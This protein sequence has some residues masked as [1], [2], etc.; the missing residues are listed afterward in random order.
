MKIIPSHVDAG[1]KFRPQTIH[2]NL[3]GS[4][5]FQHEHVYNINEEFFREKLYLRNLVILLF[6]CCKSIR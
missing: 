4:L 2:Q 1:F 6:T 5:Y 3:S